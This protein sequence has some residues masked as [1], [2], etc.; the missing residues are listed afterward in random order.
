[1]AFS[2]RRA[3]EQSLVFSEDT[4]EELVAWKG[5]LLDEILDLKEQRD[6]LFRDVE[7]PAYVDK[8]QNLVDT[9]KKK[10]SSLQD[11]ISKLEQHK[12]E[13]Y[14]VKIVGHLKELAD[15]EELYKKTAI[16]IKREIKDLADEFK[17]I[18]DEV[19]SREELGKTLKEAQDVG[20]ASYKSMELEA[21]EKLDAI[22]EKIK[23]QDEV[24]LAERK[25]FNEQVATFECR[26]ESFDKEKETFNTQKREGQDKLAADSASL[27]NSTKEMDKLKLGLANK[28]AQMDAEL[29]KYQESNEE[30]K[31][32][33]D[34]MRSWRDRLDK[35]EALILQREKDLDENW[36]VF[37]KEKNG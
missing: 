3:Y 35:R 31:V 22:N 17:C 14:E 19:V 7:L 26:K 24:L 6:L 33:R 1:M 20:M 36:T 2:A 13:D 9:L 11:A 21:E 15:R 4:Q 16:A 10:R 18:K 27:E 23:L 37:M 32:V 30:I 34:E 12:I 28:T 5:E 8:L 29:T 25:T